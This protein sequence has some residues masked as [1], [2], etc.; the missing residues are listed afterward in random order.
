[1]RAEKSSPAM[2]LTT[3]LDALGES[4]GSGDLRALGPLAVRLDE[5]ALL[6]TRGTHRLT[7]DE[8][9]VLRQKAE[10]QM[11]LLGAARDGLTAAIRRVE[12]VS[13]A[14]GELSTY[15][16]EGHGRTLRFQPSS[17]EQRA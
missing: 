6:L 16:R 13:R 1:M 7:R 9:E 14:S 15:D 3:C 17:L 2:E 12:L 10:R 8:L 5:L 4:L 11:R